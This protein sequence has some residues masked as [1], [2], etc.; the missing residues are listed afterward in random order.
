MRIRYALAAAAMLW[1]SAAH[2]QT[3]NT[4]PF[5]TVVSVP[6]TAVMNAVSANPSRR[7]LVICNSNATAANIITV[8]FGTITPTDGVGLIIPGGQVQASCFQLQ[9]P[10]S[11]GGIGAQINMIGHVAGPT[12]VTVLEF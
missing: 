5:Q 2:A 1:G 10:A 11:T 3:T 9:V 12:S 4:G 7:G 8:S 6:N